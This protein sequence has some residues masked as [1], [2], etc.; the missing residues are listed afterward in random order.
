MQA[1]LHRRD[2]VPARISDEELMRQVADGDEQ[3]FAQL[4][5]RHLQA[6]H[7]YLMRLLGNAADA[8]DLAQETLVRLWT[9]AGGFRPGKVRLTTWLHR[10]AH[11]LA[12]DLLRKPGR[13]AQQLDFDPPSGSDSLEA[14]RSQDEQQQRLAWALGAL[15]AN[16]RDAVLLRHQQ[17]LSNPEAAKVLGVSVRA[18]ESLQS[19]GR[20]R[21]KALLK[22]EPAPARSRAIHSGCK[23]AAQRQSEGANP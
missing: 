2:P 22:S 6:I 14:L 1:N 21:L 12:V 13:D 15:P 9:K 20:R 10:I 4:L 8:E 18:L 3:A 23:G 17:G 11:N 19:R 16:Q 5:D 7:R